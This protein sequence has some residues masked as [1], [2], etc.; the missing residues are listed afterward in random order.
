[1]EAQAALLSAFVATTHQLDG[2]H[3]GADCQPDGSINVWARIGDGKKMRAVLTTDSNVTETV[4]AIAI[5]AIKRALE[6]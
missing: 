2:L 6:T 1:M 4:K 5:T 3:F